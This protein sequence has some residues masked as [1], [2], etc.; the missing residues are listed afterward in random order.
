MSGA[1]EVSLC[2]TRALAAITNK[3][4]VALFTADAL[5]RTHG[6]FKV[7]DTLLVAYVGLVIFTPFSDRVSQ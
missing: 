4:L 1:R 2:L 3:S 5:N 6:H 7:S